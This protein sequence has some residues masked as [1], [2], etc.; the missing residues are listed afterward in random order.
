METV[1]LHTEV[2]KCLRFWMFFQSLGKDDL[3]NICEFYY[4]GV[5]PKIGVS[6]NG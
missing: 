5:E 6:Q 2:P 3:W 1:S 4:V